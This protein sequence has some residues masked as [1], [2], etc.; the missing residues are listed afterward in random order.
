M[1]TEVE[2]KFLGIHVSALQK[3]LASIKAKCAHPERLMRRK[4]FDYPDHSLEKKGA[5]IRVRDEGDQITLTLKQL[6]DRTLHGTKEITII[7]SDFEKAC[8]F[9]LASGFIQTSY[10][11]TKREKWLLDGA[12]ITIDTWP[13]IPTFVECEARDEQALRSA[14]K[15]LGFDWSDAMHGSVET[16][17]QKYFDVTEAEVDSLESITFVSVPSWLEAKRRS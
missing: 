15:T 9:L 6:N 11:E 16:A 14:V 12:E 3:R 2:A 8:Q 10:Q 4:V 1:E 17:Y 13:W 7:V 5:W